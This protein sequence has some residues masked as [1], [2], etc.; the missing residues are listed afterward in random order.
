MFFLPP[1]T[2][3]VIFNLVVLLLVLHSIPSNNKLQ[4]VNLR[5]KIANEIIL[6]SIAKRAKAVCSLSVLFGLSWL[7]GVLGFFIQSTVLSYLF[8]VFCSLQGCFFFIF[9]IWMKQDLRTSWW[10]R[11][12][13]FRHRVITGSH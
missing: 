4:Q 2:F 3:T 6:R 11:V 7:F 8:A 10:V 5:Q 12:T 9:F 13:T 1:V